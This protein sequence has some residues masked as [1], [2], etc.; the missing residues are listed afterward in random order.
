AERSCTA[1]WARRWRRSTATTARWPRTWRTTTSS[2]SAGSRRRA[3]AWRLG[4]PRTLVQSLLNLGNVHVLAGYPRTGFTWLMEAYDRAAEL[5]D[6]RLFL[7]PLWVATEIMMDDSP[8]QAVEKLDEVVEMARRVGNKPI[9][10]H[11]LGS[12]TAALARLGEFE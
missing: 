7:L 2:A 11:A 3:G 12:K 9:E 6:D 8:A 4:D 10:A 5:G 1:A